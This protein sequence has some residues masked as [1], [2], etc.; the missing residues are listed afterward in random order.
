MVDQL[1]S[2][3]DFRIVTTDRDL[4]CRSTY[5]GVVTGRWIQVGNASVYYTTPGRRAL[6]HIAALMTQTD[7]AVVYLNSF[8]D[9]VFTAQPLI[10]RF[11][12]LAPRTPIVIA[13]RG[14]FS[15]GALALK[16]WKKIPYIAAFKQLDVLKQATWQASSEREVAD[17]SGVMGSKSQTVKQIDIKIATD[18]VRDVSKEALSASCLS[19]HIAPNLSGESDKTVEAAK[20]AQRLLGQPL[21]VCFL[22]RIAPMKNLDYA[23]H[24]L[25][26]VREPVKFSIYGP[27]EDAAYWLQC[28]QLI[29]ALPANVTV[30]V[31]GSVEHR[32][33]MATMEQHDLFFLPTRGENF[34]HVIYEALRAGTPVLISDQ[35][36]WS[37][38]EQRGAGWAMPLTDPACFARVID[39]V[40]LWSADVAAAAGERAAEYAQAVGSSEDVR[41]AN[42]SLFRNACAVS[43]MPPITK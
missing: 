16:S 13:P 42:L 25:T 5:P 3:F 22:S 26:Q 34:G 37:Q 11:L 33:V 14:E 8:F 32:H 35:T 18:F 31:R 30:D 28:Q 41:Q 36:P 9:P 39:E 12:G 27:Q 4:G 21:R 29:A 7:H 38:L 23:L 43:P 10:A 6:R 24:V 1:S 20:R 19:I 17:I 2:D 40:S 15:P